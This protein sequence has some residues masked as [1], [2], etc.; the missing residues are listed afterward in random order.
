[1]RFEFDSTAYRIEAEDG[2]EKFNCSCSYQYYGLCKKLLSPSQYENHI[3]LSKDGIFNV[4]KVRLN[5]G[6][7]YMKNNPF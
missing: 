7:E 3:A 6:I 2:S 1:M 4:S 5:A